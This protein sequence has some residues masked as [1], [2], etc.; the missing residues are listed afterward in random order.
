MPEIAEVARCV[1]FLRLHLKG[2]T[3]ANV[4]APDDAKIF[5]TVGC[6]GPAFEKAV[7]GR[8]VVSVGSQGKYFWITF[9]KPPHPVMHLGM[10]GWVHIKGDQTAYTN[11]YKKMKP[12]EAE[13]WPPKFWK[14]QLE[15]EGPNKVEVAFTDPRRFG[16]V[17]LVDCPGADIRSYTPLKENG[18]D[19]VVDL[20]VFTEAYLRGKM[21]ARHVPIKA[22]LLDQTTISGIGN[23]VADEVLFQAR[24]HP[25]QYCD[26]F[27]E[28]EIKG[29]FDSIRFV[30]QTAVD[31]LGDSDE[32]PSDWLFNYRWGKGD[33]KGGATSLPSGEKLAFLT[34][35]GRTSCYAP[36]RQ[37][38]TGKV[39]P[40]AKEVPI[41][42]DEKPAKGKRGR[43][44]KEEDEEEEQAPPPKKGRKAK[45]EDEEEDAPPAKK[46]RGAA[47]AKIEDEEE[48]DAPP[49]KKKRGAT[50][51]KARAAPKVKKEE[52]QLEVNGDDL[53]RRRSG[54]LRK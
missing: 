13:M 47:K 31:K 38:K 51:A 35:G 22:L 33:K 18:P 54:R 25:E 8:T 52:V 26:D 12:E 29:I 1:H 42:A 37:K 14:F 32:F 45:V 9:D 17:R 6:S 19:P 49:A 21:Q 27:S 23:W 40:S 16:R 11:Y 44:V 36:G 46:K 3:I 5:G 39:V 48:E 28:A 24:A 4:I 41:D 43:K 34:V 15:T 10:T 20:D 30:C 7:K 2:K 50:T 53:G